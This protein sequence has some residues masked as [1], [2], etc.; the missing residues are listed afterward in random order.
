MAKYGESNGGSEQRALSGEEGLAGA[1]PEQALR[2][3]VASLEA[4]LGHLRVLARERH[5]L[6]HEVEELRRQKHELLNATSQRQNEFLAMLAHE[7]RNPLAPLSMSASLLDGMAASDAQAGQVGQVA[8]VIRRQVDHM[9]HLLDDLLD[10]ARIS[11]GKISLT[12][13]PQSLA[14]AV[15]QALETVGPRLRERRQH[16]ELALAP[17]RLVVEGDP[18]RLTQVFTNLLSNASKYTGD[19][20]RIRLSVQR[21]GDKALVVVEDD[22]AGIAPDVLPRIFDLFTQGPRSL[23]RSEGGLGVGLSVVRNLVSMHGGTVDACSAGL[24]QGS[25]FTVRLPLSSAPPQRPLEAG[26]DGGERPAR[27]LLVEDNPDAC[28]TLGIL[29]RMA[30]HEVETAA[31][32]MAGLARARDGDFDVLICDIGLPGIDGYRVIEGVRAANGSGRPFAIAL[33]GYGQAEDRERAHA[34]G[35]DRYL[36]KPAIPETLLKLVTEAHGAGGAARTN[37]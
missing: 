16:L 31:D 11:R 8:R 18:V 13:Q 14:D 17:E 7:L 12:V 21:E 33:S 32:G 28:E 36:V 4:E 20:G 30:G 5:E 27:I 25:R 1:L 26:A 22:G 29:L 6:M 9:A 2:K 24:G 3:H 10:A 37:A 15:E 23:A 34:A 35:F 19:G